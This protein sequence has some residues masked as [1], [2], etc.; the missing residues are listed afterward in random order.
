[1]IQAFGCAMRRPTIF[2]TPEFVFQL[3]F[4]PERAALL[5]SG[6]KIQPKRTLETGFKYQYPKIIDACREVS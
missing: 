3:I 4:G 1:M 6:A 5:L 2:T